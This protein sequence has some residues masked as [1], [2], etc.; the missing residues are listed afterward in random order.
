MATYLFLLMGN[1]GSGYSFVP[2]NGGKGG[3]GYSFVPTN[4]GKGGSDFS[5]VPGDHQLVYLPS[6][7]C[8]MVLSLLFRCPHL[9]S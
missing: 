9:H 8:Q 1:G 4:R 7:C 3:S 5:F 6:S 2:T